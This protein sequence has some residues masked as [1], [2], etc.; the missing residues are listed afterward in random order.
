MPRQPQR[1]RHVPGGAMQG[2]ALMQALPKSIHIG[3]FAQQ[4]LTRLGLV[5]LALGLRGI[6]RFR[7]PSRVAARARL[8]AS[9]PGRP[10]ETLRDRPAIGGDDPE[11]QGVWSAHLA[12]MARIAAGA[13]ST[14]RL[15]VSNATVND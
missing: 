8:D 4:P 9:L 2:R 10:L 11:A 12:R 3:K 6:G 1:A 15:R 5:A 14:A 7:W 13:R